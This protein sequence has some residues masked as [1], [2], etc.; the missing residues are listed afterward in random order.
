MRVHFVNEESIFSPSHTWLNSASVEKAG[1]IRA[2][3]PQIDEILKIINN[4]KCKQHSDKI[5]SIKHLEF[6]ADIPLRH[7][8]ELFS[9]EEADPTLM[10]IDCIN[11]HYHHIS[12]ALTYILRIYNIKKLHIKFKL[13]DNSLIIFMVCIYSFVSSVIFKILIITSNL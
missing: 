2:V 9:S 7:P 11:N 12:F 6:H 5:I 8:W 4:Y 13:Y 1:K 3:Y 10:R